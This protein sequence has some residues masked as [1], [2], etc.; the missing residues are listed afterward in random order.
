SRYATIHLDPLRRPFAPARPPKQGVAFHRSCRPPAIAKRPG[1]YGAGGA[2][3]A[4]SR[5]TGV[6]ILTRHIILDND[7]DFEGWRSAA[8]ALALHDVAPRDVVWRAS[9]NE[10]D[11][12]ASAAA[13][14]PD[15][16]H[17]LTF[18]VPAQFIELAQTAILHRDPK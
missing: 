7:T 1:E 14:L 13:V 12:F 9:G 3:E 8:R 4:E 15:G 5:A 6:R 10:P 17:D 2:A 11:L 18:N 16:P